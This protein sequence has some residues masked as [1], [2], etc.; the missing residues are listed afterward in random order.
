MQVTVRDKSKNSE[1]LGDGASRTDTKL[2]KREIVN[3]DEEYLKKIFALYGDGESM[4]MEGFE[5]LIRNI[6]RIVPNKKHEE[7]EQ[8]SYSNNSKQ[9][10]RNAYREKN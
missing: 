4:K 10:V 1:K 5:K 6:L 3:H 2:V 8:T 7:I 9:M